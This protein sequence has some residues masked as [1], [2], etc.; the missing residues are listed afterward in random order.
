MPCI[1]VGWHATRRGVTLCHLKFRQ[2][3]GTSC[4]LISLIEPSGAFGC[5]GAWKARQ[6]PS[7]WS[8][9]SSLIQGGSRCGVGRCDAYGLWGRDGVG[10]MNHKP[11]C[12]I[13]MLGS[14]GIVLPSHIGS[15]DS[16]TN[17]S[18]A[19]QMAFAKTNKPPS[20]I[21]VDDFQK[22]AGGTSR[23]SC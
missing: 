21:W 14:T 13:T 5:L 8:C 9:L 17:M 19:F 23:S 6:S 3:E 7:G 4:T 10:H 12:P 20:Q 1:I 15:T 18:E 16:W 22:W 11:S 2:R